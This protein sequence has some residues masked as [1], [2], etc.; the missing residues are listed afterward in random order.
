[1][2]TSSHARK[3]RLWDPAIVRPALLE[4]LRKLDPRAMVR[5]GNG[6]SLMPLLARLPIPWRDR[7][8]R[9]QFGLQFSAIPEH[10]P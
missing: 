9:R 10:S 5:I 8:L 1:M 3:P 7:L 2:T 4:A 6:S